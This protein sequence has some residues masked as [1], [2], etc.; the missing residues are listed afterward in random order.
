[1]NIKQQIDDVVKHLEEVEDIKLEN[2]AKKDPEGLGDTLERVF[3]KFGITEETI[4]KAAGI[5]GCGCQKRK[6]FLNKIFP[7]R[8]RKNEAK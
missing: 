1:M 3:A 8:K 5:G 7:Y 2:F 4:Q 6:K